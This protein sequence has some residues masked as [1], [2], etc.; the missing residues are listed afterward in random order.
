M[1]STEPAT[2]M[3][4]QWEV[5]QFLY[6]EAELLDERRFAEW[7]ELFSGPGRYRVY[8]A[9]YI[10]PDIKGTTK[11]IL[12]S[13]VLAADDDFEFIGVRVARLERNLAVCEVPASLTR[14]FVTNV[15]ATQLGGEIEARYNTALVQNRNGADVMVGRRVDRLR[16]VDGALR[17]ADRCAYLDHQVLPR[18]LSS[19]V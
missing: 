9:D 11:P 16:R 2:A 14:H 18:T 10:G 6:R 8:V 19:F 13:P 7:L 4:L 12:P 15:Q 17:I 1:I 5:A 3:A